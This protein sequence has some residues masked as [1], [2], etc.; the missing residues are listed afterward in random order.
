MAFVISDRCLK[1][2]ACDSECPNNAI[3]EEEKEIPYRLL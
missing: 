1:C 3:I 2:G